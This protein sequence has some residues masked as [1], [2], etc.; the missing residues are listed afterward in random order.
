MVKPG[1]KNISVFIDPE[2][3][4]MFKQYCDASGTKQ[5]AAIEGAIR[6][7]LSQ[8]PQ[9]QS[10]WIQNKAKPVFSAD[11]DKN[12]IYADLDLL[13]RTFQAVNAKIR[14]SESARKKIR[15]PSKRR[16]TG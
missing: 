4:D 16:G 1:E 6:L 5:Y 7:W 15:G 3:S 13:A 2:V 8:T 9:Q 10:D 12:E 14:R 11:P